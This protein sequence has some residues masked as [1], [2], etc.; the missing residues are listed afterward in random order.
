M[1]GVL[2]GVC[3]VGRGSVGA[4]AVIVLFSTNIWFGSLV[5]L[6]KAIIINTTIIITAGIITGILNILEP[7][8]QNL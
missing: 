2:V 6:E 8:I 5:M 1:P 3:G 7:F 4:G